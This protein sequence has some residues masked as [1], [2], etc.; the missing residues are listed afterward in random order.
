MRKSKQKVTKQC[1]TCNRYIR[2]VS[3]YYRNNG[4]YCNKKCFKKYQKKLL[5]EK[6]DE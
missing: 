1:P 4:Y 2:R 5:E 6:K 3:W